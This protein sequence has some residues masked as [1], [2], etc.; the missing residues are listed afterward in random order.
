MIIGLGTDLCSL[1]RIERGLLRFGEHFCRR[2]L[3]EAEHALMPSSPSGRTAFVAGRFAAKEAA[4]KA[5]GTG[6]ACGITMQDVEILNLP[7]GQ[8]ELHLHGAAAKRAEE[9]GVRHLH[10]SLSHERD[11]AGAVVILED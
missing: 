1:P 4:V 6:F 5:L 3:G 7:S 8:P 10:V 2:I 9:L 11:V